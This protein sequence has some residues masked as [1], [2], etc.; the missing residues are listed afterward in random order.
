MYT[1]K[2]MKPH[3]LMLENV[4][5]GTGNPPPCNYKLVS[6]GQKRK[7][8]VATMTLRTANMGL[9]LLLALSQL[10]CSDF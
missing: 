5:H 7:E 2:V 4:W 1:A 10:A 9:D 3:A 6:K 8:K